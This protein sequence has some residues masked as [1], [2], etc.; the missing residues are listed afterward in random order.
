[1]VIMTREVSVNLC[2]LQKWRVLLEM[3]TPVVGIEFADS[4]SIF[5]I[6]VKVVRSLF[7]VGEK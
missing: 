4:L 6:K 1:M 3:L 5:E 7:N 2:F